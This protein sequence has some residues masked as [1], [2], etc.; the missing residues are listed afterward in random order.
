[1]TSV[2]SNSLQHAALLLGRIG[3][4]PIF[5]FSGIAKV[6]AYAATQQYMDSMGVPGVLLPMVIA[7]EVGG[8]LAVLAGLLTRSAAIG[9]ALFSLAAGILFHFDPADQNQMTHFFKNITIAGGLVILAVQGAGRYSLDALFAKRD[10]G[11]EPA[12]GGR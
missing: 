3:L 5:V 2:A 12:F 1:M 11:L 9:L 10:S 8:G 7:A 6:G 4:A